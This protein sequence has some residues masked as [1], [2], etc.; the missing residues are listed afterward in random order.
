MNIRFS[1]LPVFLFIPLLL[2][3][4]PKPSPNP[5]RVNLLLI[6]VDTLRADRLGCYGYDKPTSPA[7]DRLAGESVRFDNAI[8]PSSWTLP[9]VISILTGLYPSAHGVEHFSS[10]LA[11]KTPTLGTLLQ[12]AGYRTYAA[13]SHAVIDPAQ[14]GTARGFEKV[15]YYALSHWEISSPRYTDDAIAW[16][17]GDGKDSRPWCAWLHYYDPHYNYI[18]HDEFRSLYSMDID[19]FDPKDYDIMEVKKRGVQTLRADE[20]QYLSDLYDGEI[21]YT[22]FHIGRLLDFL[23]DRQMLEN[24][25]V[26]L[27]SDHGESL[28]EHGELDHTQVIYDT[29]AHVPLIV[30]IPHALGDLGKVASRGSV[31]HAPVMTVDVLPSI[32]D[33][34]EIV[35]PSVLDGQ[36]LFEVA[37]WDPRLRITET[38]KIGQDAVSFI[39]ARRSDNKAVMDRISRDLH[40]FNLIQDPREEQNLYQPGSEPARDLLCNSV[41]W[42]ERPAVRL[43]PKKSATLEPDLRANLKSI[44]YI[45]EGPS[46]VPDKGLKDLLKEAGIDCP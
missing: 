8:T 14:F 15:S 36:N 40:L 16:I 1:Q 20:F 17:Q 12:N 24:T 11:D 26:I 28:G 45:G 2:A 10:T 18:P 25:L 21:A 30:R 22:D 42:S 38:N 34:L 27:T 37:E 41:K 31:N 5:E 13:I 9:S 43:V 7:I 35:R 6:T 46:A 44:G 32:L 23:R 19:A 39:A 33:W 4:G 3:C 29:V